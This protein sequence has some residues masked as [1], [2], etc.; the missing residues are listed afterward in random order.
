MAKRVKT[1]PGVASWGIDVPSCDHGRAVLACK[2]DEC[3]T[4]E[5]YVRSTFE[6]LSMWVEPDG[7]LALL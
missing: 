3:P 5:D 7:Q 2:A 4:R 6:Q 1:E